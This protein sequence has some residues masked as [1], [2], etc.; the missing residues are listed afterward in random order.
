MTVEIAALGVVLVLIGV[1]AFYGVKYAPPTPTSPRVR[2]VML[3]TLPAALTGT[4]H[5][6][7]SGWG[8]LAFP[9]ARRYPHCR[10]VAHEISP[11]PWLVS[12]LR[13]ALFP[14]PN[15]EMKLGDFANADLGDAG[16]VVCYLFPGV[17]E[18]LR[19]RFEAELRPGTLV[20]CNT[21]AL[22]GWS[23]VTEKTAPDL[24]RSSVFLYR[25]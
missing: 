15:L 5:E 13:Q 20:L 3:D 10:V 22:R 18:Q 24:F 8:T 19:V 21:F 16:L 9:L 23:P 6:L 14:A 12:R 7:G 25:R 11:V 17:M 4:I 1:I 2:A